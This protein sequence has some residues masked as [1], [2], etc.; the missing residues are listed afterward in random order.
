M[1]TLSC[2]YK[3]PAVPILLREEGQWKNMI[4]V[5]KDRKPKHFRFRVQRK[6]HQTTAPLT[7]GE[8]KTI[9]ILEMEVV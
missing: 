7:T 2:L 8:D 5:G 9:T 1:C 6:N 3:S 4:N